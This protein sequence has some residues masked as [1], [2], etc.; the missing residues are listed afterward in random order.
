MSAKLVRVLLVGESA[1][2]SW[3]L[4]QRLEKQ[5]CECHVA[6]SCGDA[7][8]LSADDAFDLV[9]CTDQMEEIRALTESLVGSATTVFRR[10]PVEDSC[11]WLPAVRAGRKCLGA[12]ALRPGEF[13]CFLD[14]LVDEIKS[15]KYRMGEV[16]APSD[17][18]RQGCP[19][20]A[21]LGQP[22][23]T[24]VHDKR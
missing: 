22:P 18:P 3:S 6:A 17:K 24:E 9:L 21:V 2:G 14:G 23:I 4:L 20:M 5:G 7:A 11:W 15:V 12:P 13:A 16:M 19:K 10:H 8:R 1:K